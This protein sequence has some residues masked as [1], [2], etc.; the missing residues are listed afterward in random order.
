MFGFGIFGVG[1]SEFSESD[2]RIRNFFGVRC[3][4]F[5]E[6]DVRIRNFFGVRCSE[7]LE[8]DVRI[9]RRRMF[10]FGIFLSWMFGSDCGFRLRMFGFLGLEPAQ[11]VETYD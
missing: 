3:S 6:S 1:F 9:F 7:F 8:S 10:G 11:L 4:E 5:L 2:V